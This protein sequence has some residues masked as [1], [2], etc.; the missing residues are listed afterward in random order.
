MKRL[1]TL[2]AAGT[3]ALLSAETSRAAVMGTNTWVGADS[4]GLWATAANWR[5]VASDGTANGD[6]TTTFNVDADYV[7]DFS[8]LADGAI[9]IGDCANPIRIAG[10]T[11]ADNRG[12]VTLEPDTGRSQ[13]ND[14][15]FSK[16]QAFVSV[17]TGT[18]V[19]FKLRREDA[20]SYDAGTVVQFAG[21]G[22]F[23]YAVD[24]LGLRATFL[25]SDG[26]KFVLPQK[27]PANWR[28]FRTVALKFLDS[29][30]SLDIQADGALFSSIESAADVAPRVLLNGHSLGFA[31]A[32]GT[33]L[34]ARVF[35]G[36]FEGPGN[37]SFQGGFVTQ[38]TNA[39]PFREGARLVVQNAELAASADALPSVAVEE[40]GVLQLSESASVGA[41]AGGSAEGRIR[42]NDGARLTVGGTDSPAASTYS[43]RLVGGGSLVKE[44]AG[45]T[46][47][48]DGVNDYTGG[49]EVKAGTLAVKAAPL[50]TDGLVAHYTFDDPDNLGKDALG[51]ADLAGTG[52]T[53]VAGV[54][55]CAAHFALQNAEETTGS[56]LKLT[57]SL[58]EA[59]LPVGNESV[60]F[61][62]WVRPEKSDV[63]GTVFSLYGSWVAGQMH[64]LRC[65]FG[66]SAI[67]ENGSG[68]EATSSSSSRT[69]NLQDG[70]WHHVVCTYDSLG[71]KALYVDG[72]LV[73]EK[74]IDAQLAVDVKASFSIGYGV[75]DF[76][77]SGD[78]DD[79]RVYRRVLSAED[80]RSL[81]AMK[82]P[83][84]GMNPAAD[85]PKP[86]VRYTFDDSEHPFADSSGNGF[87]LVAG[88]AEKS[89]AHVTARTGAFGGCVKLDGKSYLK[90]SAFPSGIPTAGSFS[91]SLRLQPGGDASGANYVF[92]G[93]ASATD[94]QFFRVNEHSN[95][96]LCP[97]AGFSTSSANDLSDLDL[98][99][100]KSGY[101]SSV[102]NAATWRHIVYVYEA[103]TKCLA[104]YRDGHF[105]GAKI[106]PTAYAASQGIF[107]IGFGS[108]GPVDKDGK[109]ILAKCYLDD[110]RVFDCPLTAAQVRTLAQSLETGSVGSALPTEGV[111]SVSADAT[112]R[113]VGVGTVVPALSG[114]GRVEVEGGASLTLKDA[115]TFTGTVSGCGSL[116]L[117][118]AFKGTFADD[119]AG[120]LGLSDTLVTDAN[121]SGLP[122]A[123]YPD[124]GL[125]IPEKGTLTLNYDDVSQLK[126]RR[127]VLAEAKE[128]DAPADFAGWKVVPEDE[129]HYRPTFFVEPGKNGV[130]RFVVRMHYKRGIALIIR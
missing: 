100:T 74:L 37:V 9:V 39:N 48:L 26:L 123:S 16:E 81:Y 42:W 30:S 65:V 109:R 115:A 56:Y 120:R 102:G 72:Q 93:A 34:D 127:L 98:I 119:F 59:G 4:G 83:A 71:K 103:S 3:A 22:A 12:T 110:V 52:V 105:V 82:A 108:V 31:Y 64:L 35:G 36:T 78:L 23:Q 28:S 33:G 87:D 121:G 53:A 20:W 38:L 128:F 118:G 89:P 54:M 126:F 94:G 112:L 114:A 129:E 2:A 66:K 63:W 25:L 124:R 51:R 61:A 6:A 122:V 68:F 80:V 107:A 111:V 21:G 47:T 101:D 17:G 57:K 45:Y 58:A 11:F 67:H 29:A 18:T 13:K 40:N 7:Y 96:T 55:G 130:Q 88:D 91:V 15:F 44:G 24:G 117:A 86:V 62:F 46:L 27:M 85:L 73:D 5:S 14:F 50:V 8:S 116:Y 113:A 69:I 106:V 19:M 79:Y 90:T 92:W 10:L 125:T 97:D 77:Y 49:T 41:L 43:A 32:V 104:A 76:Q 70:A 95:L 99:L 75:K 60:S 1:I 84:T